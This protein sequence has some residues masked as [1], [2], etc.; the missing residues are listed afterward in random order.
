MN[1]TL[2]NLWIILPM[3]IAVLSVSLGFLY[4]R[5]R[6]RL[7]G[8]LLNL[9]NTCFANSVIQALASCPPLLEYLSYSDSE[10]DLMILDLAES[11]N[12]FSTCPKNPKSVL[13]A[14]SM[15]S[16]TKLAYEQQDAHEF[17]ISLTNQLSHAIYQND[18]VST[19]TNEL[20]IHGMFLGQGVGLGWKPLRSPIKGFL[21]MRLCCQACGYK[22]LLTFVF[23][24]SQEVFCQFNII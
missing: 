18:F 3:S 15:T 1:S 16:R 8:G 13:N 2:A 24:S 5:K 9:G 20:P 7:P 21:A 23:L 12:E 14:L 22:V 4:P 11:L 19:L 10:I 17:L 6:K